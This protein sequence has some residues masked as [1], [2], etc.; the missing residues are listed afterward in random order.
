VV[1]DAGRAL[2]ARASSSDSSVAPARF[3]RP[4]A[5]ARAADGVTFVAGLVV[6]RGTITVTALG[7]DGAT[8]WTRDVITG[9]AWTAN[10]TL[11]VV[12]AKASAIVVWRGLRAGQE[13]TIAVTIGPDGRVDGEPF[14]V[15]AAAC[16]TGSELAWIDRDAKSGW[17]VRTQAF[18][19][20]PH[21]PVAALTLSEDRDPALFCG[22]QRVFALGDGD[23][24]VILSASNAGVRA[25]AIR[26]IQD[27]DFRGDDQRGHE[28]YAVGDVLGIVRIGTEGSLA[29]R[30][31][32]EGHASPW[33]R[34]GRKL[35]EA[36]DVTLV[37]A[38][39]RSAVVAFTRETG[40]V[41]DSSGVSSL[42]AFVWERA[43][44]R[45]VS[46]RLAPPDASRVRGP[47]W[48]GAVPGGGVVVGWAERSARSDSG[49]APIVGLSYRTVS[50]DAL[51]DVH[52]LERPADELVDAGCDDKHC[53]AVALARAVGEDGGQPEVAQVVAYP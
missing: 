38:D 52:Q 43:G 25:P 32:T 16:T 18:D 11:A 13:V 21:A 1:D 49:E 14:A 17:V 22:A 45:S 19:A 50:V 51:G 31:V 10:A 34:F 29:S 28:L 30:E 5:A 2:P 12:R 7:P 46:Y 48:S 47:F 41:G 37:D 33:H 27:S 3:S 40:A 8:R 20:H 39:D 24:D 15:G 35:T 44:S 23:T 42:E 36:D 26:V 4:F 9:I 6:P 53:Y